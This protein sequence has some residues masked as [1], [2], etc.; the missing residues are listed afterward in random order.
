MSEEPTIAHQLREAAAIIMCRRHMLQFSIE[1]NTIYRDMAADDL[2][3]INRQAE[4][5]VELVDK[6]EL[7]YPEQAQKVEALTENQLQGA[8]Y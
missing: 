5:V 2:A 1:H 8:P 4:I 7:Q 6:L 3:S